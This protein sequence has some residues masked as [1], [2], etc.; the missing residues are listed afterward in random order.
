MRKISAPPLCAA[1]VLIAFFAFAGCQTM[2]PES[3]EPP[4]AAAQ[5]VVE[6]PEPL[7]PVVEV[8]LWPQPFAAGMGE[9]LF[10]EISVE[11]GT[12]VAVWSVRVMDVD[13][14]SE[15]FYEISGVGE[16]PG[17]LVWDGIGFSGVAM[18]QGAVYPGVVTVTSVYGPTATVEIYVLASD[19]ALTLVMIVPPIFFGPDSD[20]FWGVAEADEN[21]AT[22]AR[23][24]EIFARFEGY[25]LRIEGHANPTTPPGT[26]ER[27]EEEIGTESVLGLQPLSDWRAQAVLERLVELGV[28]RE[29]LSAAG[30]GGSRVVAD[31]RDVGNWWR[32][33]R[34][35]FILVR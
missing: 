24:A 5:P 27:E 29:R 9:E 7:V 34:V 14:P 12:P 16:V 8:A 22:L 32:N 33:R 13:Y 18:R 6:E 11:A 23:I 26:P 28:E 10:I 1:I 15:L 4:P 2:P 21:E 20:S 3:V 25:S 35:E 31:F 17:L 30:M 19:P